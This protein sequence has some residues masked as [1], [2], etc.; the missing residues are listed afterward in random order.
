MSKAFS[1]FRL[2][3]QCNHGWQRP[4]LTAL[5]HHEYVPFEIREAIQASLDV[6]D[7]AIE[8]IADCESYAEWD[9][10]WKAYLDEQF[11]LKMEDFFSVL[12]K[13]SPLEQPLDEGVRVSEEEFKTGVIGFRV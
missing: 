13:K 10:H 9:K 5:A 2:V 4:I 6:S 3:A 11:G 7:D 8:I 1:L 12:D